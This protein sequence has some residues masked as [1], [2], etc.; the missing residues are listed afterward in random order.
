MNDAGSGGLE[1]VASGPVLR[2]GAVEMRAE[3]VVKRA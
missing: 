3:E 1:R 2:P